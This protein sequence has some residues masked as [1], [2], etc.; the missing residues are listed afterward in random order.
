MC[1]PVADHPD[2]HAVEESSG[3]AAGKVDKIGRKREMMSG[4]KNSHTMP[5]ER[6][7]GRMPYS[8]CILMFLVRKRRLTYSIIS[9]KRTFCYDLHKTIQN[10]FRSDGG[11]DV[12]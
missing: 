11:A 6:Q 3:H 1:D 5:A 7:T 2:C 8:F 4:A 12:F 10:N 9:F